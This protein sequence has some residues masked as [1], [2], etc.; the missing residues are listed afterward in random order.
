MIA[1]YLS[2]TPSSLKCLPTLGSSLPLSLATLGLLYIWAACR[3]QSFTCASLCLHLSPT[4]RL[5]LAILD[6]CLP[7]LGCCVRLC[8]AACRLQP[9]AVAASALQ[10]FVSQ[11]WTSQALV[12]ECFDFGKPKVFGAYGGVTFFCFW[13]V[14]GLMDLWGFTIV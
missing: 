4:V 14:F 7:A 10:S 6:I 11:L 9:F 8:L 5:C 3:L 12:A 1:C 2:F 13:E